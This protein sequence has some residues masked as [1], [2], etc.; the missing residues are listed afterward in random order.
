MKN[1][2]KRRTVIIDDENQWQMILKSLIS[3]VPELSLEAVFSNTDDAYNYLKEHDI[4]LIFL[5]VQIEGSNGIEFVKKLND[6]PLIIIVSSHREFALEGYSISAIDYLVKPI[7]FNKFKIAVSKALDAITTKEKNDDTYTRLEFDRNYLLFRE[8][9]ALVKIKYDD[10]LYVNAY[11]N[12][13]KV[14]SFEKTYII[15]STL[16]QFERSL[17]Y[18]PFIRVHRSFI[19]NLNY[20]KALNKDSI[21]LEHNHQIPIGE[22]YKND[23]QEAFVEGKIIKR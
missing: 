16:T 20:I 13:I 14:V 9:Q 15:L 11:E 12:Y 8:N 1:I 22:L 5:D 4:D 23:I 17:S 19:I 18:H 6:P 3:D 2:K 21:S 10:V 7:D